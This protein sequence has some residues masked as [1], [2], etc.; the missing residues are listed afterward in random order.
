M[1]WLLRKIVGSKNERDMKKIRPLVARVNEIETSYQSLSEDALRAK[2]QEFRDR[3]AK[4]EPLDDL[5]PEAF[6]AVKNACRRL[7]GRTID[8]CGHPI[9]CVL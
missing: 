9:A 7:C 5:L 3:L 1:Q 6:A 4:G 2:T 8:V